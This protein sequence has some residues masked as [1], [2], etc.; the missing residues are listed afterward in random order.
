M[1]E[2]FKDWVPKYRLRPQH[3]SNL[4]VTQ[5]VSLDADH[6]EISSTSRNQDHWSKSDQRN[7]AKD[8]CCIQNV[9]S[10]DEILT[11]DSIHSDL[12]EDIDD[13]TASTESISDKKSSTRVCMDKFESMLREGRHATLQLLTADV[14]S[15]PAPVVVND[16]VHTNNTNN[17]VQMEYIERELMHLQPGFDIEL[18]GFDDS[19]NDQIAINDDNNCGA[20][21]N[22]ES[23][24]TI[25]SSTIPNS[26]TVNNMRRRIVINEHRQKRTLED[27]KLVED[28]NN[29][30]TN[31][32]TYMTGLS[33]DMCNGL[34]DVNGRYSD[35]QPYLAQIDEIESGI[36]NLEIAA[37]TL[38]AFVRN[39]D[40]DIQPYLA[41]IDEIES[42][43]KNLEIAACTLDAFVRNLGKLKFVINSIFLGKQYC[44]LF[45]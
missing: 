35:M 34:V 25:E 6:S 42:G 13:K 3:R 17:D 10:E 5:A 21:T 4:V 37:C 16:I 26:L 30:V 14:E 33:G 44:F 29:V 23:K 27:L 12:D 36:K 38:D 2:C 15:Y 11:V 32:Y 24:S 7:A 28:M 18:L 39:L 19:H 1:K 20:E 9:E 22:P 8:Q 40:S 45:G 31:K 43:I 41:Q